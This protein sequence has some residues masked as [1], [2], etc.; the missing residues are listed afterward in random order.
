MWLRGQERRHQ[1][2]APEADIR[3]QHV[4]DVAAD[5]EEVAMREVHHVAEVDDQRQAERHQHVEDANDQPVGEIEQNEL[6]HAP[7]PELE[8]DKKAARNVPRGF[9]QWPKPAS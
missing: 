8:S 4:G 1:Q 6:Q 5:G 9:G 7:A 2:R 3:R